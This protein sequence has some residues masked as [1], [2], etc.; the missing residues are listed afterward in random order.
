MPP[1]APGAATAQSRAR[2]R[3]VQRESGV[4]SKEHAASQHPG[5]PISRVLSWAVIYL[6]RRLPAASSGLPGARTG[7]AAPRLFPVG[8]QTRWERSRPCLALLPVGVA[9]P[10]VSPRAPVV[11]YTTF[12]PSPGRPGL[13]RLSAFLWPF[14]VGSPRPGCYPA[15]C[16]VEPGLSS[17]RACAGRDRLADLGANSMITRHRWVSRSGREGGT[18]T[19]PTPVPGLL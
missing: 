5:R 10:P 14:S 3:I 12:S 11:S 16:P 7:R 1:P 15:P 19:C 8:S 17:P 2:W 6:G 13:P 4:S 18:M 9:W